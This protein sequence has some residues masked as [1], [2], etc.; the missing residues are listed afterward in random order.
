MISYPWTRSPFYYSR[1]KGRS[2]LCPKDL[3][4]YEAKLWEELLSLHLQPIQP[5]PIDSIQLNADAKKI[6]DGYDSIQSCDWSTSVGMDANKLPKRSEP[7]S[8]P[9]WWSII[10]ISLTLSNHLS[11]ETSD[12]SRKVPP[13]LVQL[14]HM[15][16][17]GHL[18]IS[19]P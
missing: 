17:V 3:E 2:T 15:N 5:S 8:S 14:T 12:G 11:A 7:S 10:P 13:C 18:N 9:W 4:Q 6:S 16:S 19:H 1:H